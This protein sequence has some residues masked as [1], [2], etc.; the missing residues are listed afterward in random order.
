LF[1]SEQNVWTQY[2]WRFWVR[3]KWCIEK[4][5]IKLGDIV[6]VNDKGLAR[7]DWPVGVVEEAI[8][9]DDNLV[10]KAVVRIYHEGKHVSYTRPITE[11]VLSPIMGIDKIS[12][13]EKFKNM[14]HDTPRL[15]SF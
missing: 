8:K 11:L 15:I 10:R 1:L 9:S 12:G 14:L 7:N 4:P 13:K 2:Y 3:Q 5:N 6:F